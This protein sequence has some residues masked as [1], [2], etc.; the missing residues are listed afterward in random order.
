M[1]ADS[2]NQCGT[3]S[4]F[5]VGL[6]NGVCRALHGLVQFSGGVV[7]VSGVDGPQVVADVHALAEDVAQ[8]LVLDSPAEVPLEDNLLEH[9]AQTYLVAAVGRGREPDEL[10]RLE[11]FKNLSV[12]ICGSVVGLIA[13]D[14]SEVIRAEPLQPP[15]KA[16]YRR[17][18]HFLSAGMAPGPLYAVRAVKVFPGLLHQ[19]L[20]VRQNQHPLPVP[21]QVGEGH[22]L[23]QSRG[24]LHQVGA[25]GL[26]FNSG[27]AVLLVW[28]QFHVGSPFVELWDAS[29]L[30]PANVLRTK[31]LAP[32]GF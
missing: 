3:G 22:R 15:H 23:A 12:G 19:F 31:S 25:G 21:G 16:L 5:P 4:V 8:I 18:D 2:E 13:D 26:G 24:H 17:A 14:Q 10:L 32:C 30:C 1:D 7:A 28:S 27:N 11:V 29:F 9:I 6:R 20:P